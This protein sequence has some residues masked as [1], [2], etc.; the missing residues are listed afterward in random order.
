M[1]FQTVSEVKVEVVCKPL[2]ALPAAGKQHDVIL[3]LSVTG[4][5]QWAQGTPA[6]FPCAFSTAASQISSSAEIKGSLFSVG[7]FT[8]PVTALSQLF[9]AFIVSA[10]A[11]QA[12]RVFAGKIE[13]HRK[14]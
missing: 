12:G 10:P 6:A 1:N 7:I 11:L 3:V 4:I 8:A 9:T 13:M 5:P 2:A 14:M